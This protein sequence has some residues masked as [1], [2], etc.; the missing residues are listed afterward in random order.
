MPALLVAALYHADGQIDDEVYVYGSFIQSRMYHASVTCSDCHDPHSLQ[1]RA[2]G[3]ELC[4]QCHRPSTFDTA[5]H[6][7][8]DP[9]SDG[10]QCVECHMLA[11]TYMVVDPRRDHSFRVPRPDL[12]IAL[13]TP[14][15][16]TQCHRDQSD[17]W[18]AETVAAWYGSD[19]RRQTHFGTA[20]HAGRVGLAGAEA[21][22]VGLV[23]DRTQ[24]AIA[25]ATALSLLP[26]YASPASIEAYRAGLADEDPLVRAAAV[27][28]LAPFPPDQRLAVAGHLL[29]DPVKAVRI[30]AVRMLAASPLQTMSGPQRAA[31]DQATAEFIEA[32]LAAAERPETHLNLGS[33]YA[34]QG[35]FSMAEAAYRTALRL[36]RSFVPG[37]VNLADLYRV[38]RRE[39]DAEA[40][41]RE[42]LARV[43][44]SAAAHHAL[45]LA[46]VRQGQGKQAIAPLGKAAALDPDIARYGY[47]YGV[48]L[49]STGE[50]DRAIQ[51][52]EEVVERH[53]NNRNVLVALIA[54]NRDKGEIRRAR[55]FAERL[56]AAYPKDRA[57]HQILRELE[58]EQ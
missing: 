55:E 25:R 32:E 24:P 58:A 38:Q 30:E 4:G 16:C 33:L 23:I 57:V 6:H 21:L 39:T 40:I 51:V 8:H 2:A 52:L 18:A 31:L 42:A 17:Q 46:L 1:L 35:E 10:A 14:N 50:T 43:P 26:R 27:R 12:S 20:L 13:G 47:V 36:D 19:R 41:L 44:D 53:P 49:N 56:V 29:R 28:A 9:G 7:H 45:G 3:N 54:I 22:L 5:G 48:A 15:A 37:Y 34:A 11:R